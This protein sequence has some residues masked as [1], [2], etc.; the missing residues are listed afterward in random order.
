ME[1]KNEEAW[2][3]QKRKVEATAYHKLLVCNKSS[4]RALFNKDALR[5]NECLNQWH[6]SGKKRD[7]SPSERWRGSINESTSL[8]E[9][10][11]C[12]KLPGW[13]KGLFCDATE[14]CKVL[15]LCKP[16]EIMAMQVCFYL[17][18]LELLQHWKQEKQQQ[19]LWQHSNCPGQDNIINS[20]HE[21]Q[22]FSV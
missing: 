9:Q 12:Y 3:E 19:D 21:S 4:Y 7:N 8:R 1:E 5:E 16:T 6:V 11:S 2:H 22:Y 17:S 13:P 14:E 18:I 20:S 10:K 15:I